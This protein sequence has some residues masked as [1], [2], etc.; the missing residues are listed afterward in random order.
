M[1]S[2]PVELGIPAELCCPIT[3]QLMRSPVVIASGH[4][5][6]RNAILQWFAQGNFTCPLTR[7]AVD[8]EYI[9]VDSATAD[10]VSKWVR[11]QSP[12]ILKRVVSGQ[13]QVSDG[14]AEAAPPAFSGNASA[15]PTPPELVDLAAASNDDDERLALLQ[16]MVSLAMDDEIARSQ[17]VHAGV[18][19]LA[20]GILLSA[21]DREHI[22]EAA[23]LLSYLALKQRHK[24]EI[25]SQV[26]LATFRS[27]A[28][29]CAPSSKKVTKSLV[30]M[31]SQSDPHRSTSTAW[32]LW[33]LSI[34]PKYRATMLTQRTVSALVRALGAGW[35]DAC[36]LGAARA[37]RSLAMS[38]SSIQ[39]LAKANAVPALATMLYLGT[40]PKQ[41]LAA[42]SA[43]CNLANTESLSYF[44]DVLAGPSVLSAL[45]A[46]LRS[47]DPPQQRCASRML[48]GLSTKPHCLAAV[49]KAG[50]LP[51]LAE[52]V[53]SDDVVVAQAAVAA[54]LQVARNS[55]S[56]AVQPC[57]ALCRALAAMASAPR[58]SGRAGR[59][60]P[61]LGPIRA[62]SE[63]TTS[64]STWAAA[65]RAEPRIVASVLDV[66]CGADE[67]RR[68]YAACAVLGMARV[69]SSNS[70]GNDSSG[71]GAAQQPLL[72]LGSDAAPMRCLVQMLGSRNMRHA[73]T[74][75]ALLRHAAND[76]DARGLVVKA[77][78][79]HGLLEVLRDGGGRCCRK[80]D[81]AAEAAA[82]LD[83]LAKAGPWYVREIL[84][85]IRDL[86]GLQQEQ[87]ANLLPS[88][89]TAA[90]MA[91]N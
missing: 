79:V 42:G 25:V 83:C 71:G 3:G 33:L 89:L 67:M 8:P 57:M 24:D 6:E 82:A 16:R 76:A 84:D 54:S 39:L 85:A 80:H 77:G 91:D 34:S 1:D 70:G 47:G 64:C 15:A 69:S 41:V 86:P 51:A 78:G 23:E 17:M 52:A 59:S 9:V 43:L 49:C 14:Y 12:D 26:I 68:Y 55:A 63:F 35:P 74:A 81:G 28:V 30:Q 60:G 65:C 21:G 48:H 31:L 87:H 44:A 56:T 45:C 61:S 88:I 36:R 62:L 5:F 13:W 10:S 32:A 27:S 22:W 66:L 18:T 50:C 4:T 38:P 2:I 40:D 20:V 7:T 19:S 46:M 58:R 90:A 53:V 73:A 75:A 72:P 29:N 11:N 37:L